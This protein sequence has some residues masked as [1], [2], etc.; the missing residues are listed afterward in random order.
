MTKEI[1][2]DIGKGIFRKRG[3][4]ERELIQEFRFRERILLKYANEMQSVDCRSV[5]LSFGE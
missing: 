2:K 4:R 5:D 1:R 3:H